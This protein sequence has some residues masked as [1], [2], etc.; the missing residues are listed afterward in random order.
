VAV[1]SIGVAITAISV[2]GWDSHLLPLAGVIPITAGTPIPPMATVTL[3]HIMGQ[4]GT[5]IMDIIITRATTTG[6]FTEKDLPDRL[7]REQPGD[8]FVA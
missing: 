5:R 7:I 3:T 2:S 4:L 6:L 8:D 1:V